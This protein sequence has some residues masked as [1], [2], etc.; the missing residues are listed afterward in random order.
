MDN[1]LLIG[2]GAMLLM[3]I[4]IGLLP[5]RILYRLVKIIGL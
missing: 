1:I 2:L 4:A 5:D 3:T